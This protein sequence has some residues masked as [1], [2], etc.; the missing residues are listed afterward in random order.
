MGEKGL[1]TDPGVVGTGAP[2]PGIGGGDASSGAR[3]KGIMIIKTPTGGGTG[4]TLDRQPGDPSPLGGPGIVGTGAP[5]PGVVAADVSTDGAADRTTADDTWEPGA[6]VG[7]APSEAGGLVGKAA[8][9][10]VSGAPGGTA[11]GLG[12]DGLEHEHEVVQYNESA[13]E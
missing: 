6:G 10:T 8:T 7:E 12:V 1:G 4:G 5:D 3:A 11:A 2:D 9:L 13:L